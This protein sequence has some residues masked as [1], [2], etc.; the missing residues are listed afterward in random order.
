MYPE[1]IKQLFTG[2]YVLELFMIGFMSSVLTIADSKSSL[3]ALPI[4]MGIIFILTV[5]FHWMLKRNFDPLLK[6]LPITLEDEEVVVELAEADM[7][8][9]PG[10][11]IVSPLHGTERHVLVGY[12][13]KLLGHG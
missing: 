3:I 8:S 10:R 12:D 13:R 5:I 7:T 9:G 6:Y 1:A 11:S 2:V 4:I